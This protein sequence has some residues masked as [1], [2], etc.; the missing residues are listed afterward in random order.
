[1]KENH[2]YSKP[3][4]RGLSA[5]TTMNPAAGLLAAVILFSLLIYYFPF[6]ST[7]DR[8]TSFVS[9][10]FVYLIS[11]Y[12]VRRIKHYNNHHVSILAVLIIT[13]LVA[14]VIIFIFHLLGISLNIKFF[15]GGWLLITTYLLI[16]F[17]IIKNKN[18][19]KIYYIPIGRE[20]TKPCTEGFKWIR[21]EKPFMPKENKRNPCIITADLRSDLGEEW[22]AFLAKST[23]E[24]IPVY[25][26]NS[27][28]EILSGRT[29]IDH[30]YENDL[31]SLIPSKFYSNIKRI[32]DISLILLSLPLTIPIAIITAVAIKIESQGNVFFTQERIG[33]GGKKFILYKFRSMTTS[34]NSFARFAEKNDKRIT[35]VGK[36]IRKTRIDEL[37]QFLNV[38]RGDMSLIGPRPEQAHFVEKFNDEIPFYEYRH[39]VK[40]GISGW[41]QVIHGYTDNME[42]TRIKI[43]HD[44]YYIKNLSFVLD[45]LILFKTIYTVLTGFGA[46]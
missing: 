23:L 5:L 34:E 25:H 28:V 13:S 37:P 41:A 6:T 3:N 10:V 44:F 11:L 43:E 16:K 1:M 38:L 22:E 9:G 18:T 32:I 33:Q 20:I 29:R 36:H 15:W 19:T 42:D 26:S 17:V 21:L 30:L 31:G 39:I 7:Q 8:N 45:I 46:R 27:L 35:F 12:T 40:P 24:H 4:Y 14:L 2:S